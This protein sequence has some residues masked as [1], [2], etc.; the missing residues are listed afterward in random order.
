[1][2]EVKVILNPAP[3]A[4]DVSAVAEL[5]DNIAMDARGRKLKID[6]PDILTESRLVRA[7]GDAAMNAAYMQTYV[8]TAALVVEIDGE[9]MPFPMSPLQ[10][11]AAITRLGR[12]GM[13]A[14]MD[15]LI[16]K[17]KKAEEL[18][19]AAKNS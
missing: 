8:M 6:E 18:K 12:D 16:A 14:V 4:A 5:P 3:A 11:D 1:M 2:S 19:T 15:H 9:K 10:V 13:A 17:A 7:M